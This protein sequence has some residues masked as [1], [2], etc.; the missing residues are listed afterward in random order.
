MTG[1]TALLLSRFGA[2]CHEMGLSPHQA[3]ATF[4]SLP[5]G[6][7]QAAWDDLRRHIGQTRGRA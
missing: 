4:C 1:G 5:R 2:L 3:L 7:Q 6:A